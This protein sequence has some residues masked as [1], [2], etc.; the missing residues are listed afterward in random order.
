MSRASARYSVSYTH[1]TPLLYS[2]DDAEKVTDILGQ[3][4]NA[5]VQQSA[6]KKGKEH[7]V[8]VGHGTYTPG[9]ATSVSYTHLLSIKNKPLY[10]SPLR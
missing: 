5:S 9:T 1:L 8:L 10:L 6:K 4:L 3:R 7:F 2:V